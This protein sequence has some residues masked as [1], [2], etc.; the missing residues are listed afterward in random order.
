MPHITFG[1]FRLD[2]ASR[3][4]HRGVDVVPLRPKTFAVLEYLIARPGRLVTKEDLL[5][6]IWPDTAV[7]DTVLK[8]C[9]REIRDAL[10][11]DSETPRYIETAHRLGYRFIGHVLPSSLPSPVSSLI[12]RRREIDE[13]SS[14]D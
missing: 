2:T 9:V 12:G 7:T 1:P 6:A 3:R 10:G 5:A 8:V 14:A 11:D 4:M 13:I